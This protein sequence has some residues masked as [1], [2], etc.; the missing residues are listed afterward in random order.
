MFEIW[1][2]TVCLLRMGT[3]FSHLA[4]LI[5]RKLQVWV[6]NTRIA[7]TDTRNYHLDL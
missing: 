2:N 7:P 3:A 1:D 5:L 6:H 4:C